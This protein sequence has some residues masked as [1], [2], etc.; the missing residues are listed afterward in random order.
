MLAIV[1]SIIGFAMIVI[2]ALVILGVLVIA[3]RD[4]D[5]TES[6]ERDYLP[7]GLI[8]FESRGTTLSP[9]LANVRKPSSSLR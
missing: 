4:S 2:S 9:M 6:E 7:Q 1:A 8:T 5:D 3:G